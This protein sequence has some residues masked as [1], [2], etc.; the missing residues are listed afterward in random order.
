MSAAAAAR[1]T[2]LHG[3][4]K[5]T[6]VG[7]SHARYGSAGSAGSLTVISAALIRRATS[8]AT[9]TRV[10]YVACGSAGRHVGE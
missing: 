6:L 7:Q 5:S 10:A 4:P 3:E 9:W 2:Q 8:S 1:L